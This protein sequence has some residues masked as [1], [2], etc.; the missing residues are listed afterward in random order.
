MTTVPPPP[1]MAFIRVDALEAALAKLKVTSITATQLL[2]A[3]RE[4]ENNFHSRPKETGVVL[5]ST[6]PPIR[7]R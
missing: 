6:F 5:P 1:E 4:E 7:T 2:Q 3:V